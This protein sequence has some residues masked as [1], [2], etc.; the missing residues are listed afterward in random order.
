MVK[1]LPSVADD[2][3]GRM[4]ACRRTDLDLL[5]HTKLNQRPKASFY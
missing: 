2:G 1:T 5:S 3:A 4:S